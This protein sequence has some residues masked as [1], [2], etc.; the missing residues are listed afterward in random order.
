[1]LFD[2]GLPESKVSPILGSSALVPSQKN[3]RLL[4]N[5]HRRT[6]LI[7]LSVPRASC[8]YKRTRQPD[9]RDDEMHAR[10]F[11][12]FLIENPLSCTIERPYMM[13]RTLLEETHSVVPSQKNF[14]P[15][16]IY[17]VLLRGGSKF[18]NP[19]KINAT[20][21]NTGQENFLTHAASTVPNVRSGSL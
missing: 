16:T 19:R 20:K 13:Y 18:K 21:T 14:L 11:F 2:G 10:F 5:H 12:F 17:Y 8:S 3:G 1:M 6:K 4:T 15:S 7:F 9:K